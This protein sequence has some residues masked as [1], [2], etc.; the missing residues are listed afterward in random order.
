MLI[1]IFLFFETV[2]GCAAQTGLKVAILLSWVPKYW[3]YQR[4]PAHMTYVNFIL[5]AVSR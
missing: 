5:R 1:F 3:E 2:S 4:A